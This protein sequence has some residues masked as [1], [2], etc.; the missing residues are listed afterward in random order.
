MTPE[1]LYTLKEM[2]EFTRESEDNLRDLIRRGLLD[3]HQNCPGG[4]IRF[5][6]SQWQEYLALS[7][8]TGSGDNEISSGPRR[9]PVPSRRPAA[10]G[11]KVSANGRRRRGPGAYADVRMG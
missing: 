3:Y 6:N 1:P 2:S 5:T 8:K 10:R 11:S 7:L 9:R 4:R